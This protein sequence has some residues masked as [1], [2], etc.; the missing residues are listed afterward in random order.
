MIAHVVWDWNGTLFHDAPALIDSTIDAFAATGLPAIDAERYRA[1][2]TQPIP[3][4]YARL[5][6][7]EPTP[8][9]RN[10]LATA[11][12]DSY[13]RPL[14]ALALAADALVALETVAESGRTQSLLSMFPHD[15]LVPLVRRF[16]LERW[17][18]RFEGLSG[19]E[20][21]SKAGHLIRHL[22]HVGIPGSDVLVVGD[23]VDDARAARGAG[24]ACV[25]Y[26][27]G[28]HTRPDLDAEG[29]PVVGSL[30]E[31]LSVV[32]VRR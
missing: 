32:G 3:A 7:R 6:G 30:V 14:P 28:L 26:E 18:V 2:H 9:E 29:V 4:F 11:F 12:R 16:D 19:A 25:L 20:P 22:D 23:S 5:L 24:A 17:F 1:L 31:A 27:G 8:A 10:G 21:G 15:A 13:G